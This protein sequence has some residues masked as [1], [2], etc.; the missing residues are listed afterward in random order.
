[1][2]TLDIRITH[3]GIR[4]KL[5]DVLLTYNKF[6]NMLMTLIHE[7]Y[8]LYK[9]DKAK[10]DFDFL[11]S[12]EHIINAL[13]NSKKFRHP[14]HFK[15]NGQKLWKDLKEIAKKLN[16][17]N[18]TYVIKRVKDNLT[19]YKTLEKYNTDPND[20]SQ[21]NGYSVE[22][23]KEASLSL[24]RLEENL[25]G[26]RLSNGLIYININKEQTKQLTGVNKLYSARVLYNDGDLYLQISYLK[27]E[28]D[29][30]K[31]A[32]ID[33]GENNLMAV[34]VDDETTPSLL[35]S[36]KPFKDYDKMVNEIIDYLNELKSKEMLD[37]K[38]SKTE[39]NYTVK[40]TDK[41]KNIDRLINFLH[42]NRRKFLHERFN[43]M[44]KYVVEYLY[45]NGVTDLF[46][47][48]RLANHTF[49]KIP[50][51]TLLQCIEHNAQKYGIN[52]H[53]ID[54]SYTSKASCIS[55]DVK[56][57]QK[58]PKL[59]DTFNGKRKGDSFHDKAINKRFNADINAAV[60]HIIVGTG[61]S[62]AW[63]KEKMFK[64]CN[65]IKIKSENKFR[66]LLDELKSSKEVP[67]NCYF[68]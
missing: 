30:I 63:L 9:E 1:M 16:P 20:P 58:N 49:L 19:L 32:G 40:N 22:L 59:A 47:S 4:N 48:N 12:P 67:N 51:K 54:E 3:Q 8:N 43:I 2:E 42:T 11:T 24:A 10:K 33:I 18:L 6:E 23:D 28:K 57:T 41:S 17:N 29:K 7:N 45:L 53:Y 65:P 31:Y 5:I 66:K 15:N 56:S 34:F 27:T 52:V 62:F 36:G 61:K 60:N 25:I 13:Y 50:F 37:C 35:V 64:L 38:T 26:I 44:S 39:T 68:L 55:D 46:I 21:I 14:K